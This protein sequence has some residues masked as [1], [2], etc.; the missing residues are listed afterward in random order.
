MPT[1]KLAQHAHPYSNPDK[2]R[3]TTTINKN[4]NYSISDMFSHMFFFS[5][6]VLRV[7]FQ[8]HPGRIFID[9]LQD[10]LQG[11]GRGIHK[12][13]VAQPNQ[14]DLILVFIQIL[15]DSSR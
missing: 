7:A 2:K 5:Y 11:N 1:R 15:P 13:H 8:E 3:T 6:P 10:R 14:A 12:N 9:I 4:T